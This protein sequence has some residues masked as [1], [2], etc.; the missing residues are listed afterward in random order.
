MGDF[1]GQAAGGAQPF[2]ADGEFGGFRLGALLFF[3]ENLDAVA[4]QAPRPGARSSVPSGFST[5]SWSGDEP[6]VQEA[7]GH[8]SHADEK[9]EQQLREGHRNGQGVV[10][11]QREEDP[12]KICCRSLRRISVKVPIIT[13]STRPK[14]K[15]IH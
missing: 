8:K 4:A 1:G 7:P 10:Q 2:L 12:V 5:R 6:P 13:A 9:I 15:T 11:D 14:A 3:K